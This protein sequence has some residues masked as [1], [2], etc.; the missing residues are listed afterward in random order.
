[1]NPLIQ[2]KIATRIITKRFAAI[3]VLLFCLVAIQARTIIVVTNTN[4]SGFGSLRHA[5]TMAADGDTI[6][7]A[8]TG[9][10]T[11]TSDQ[12]IVNKDVVIEGPGANL[13]RINGNARHRVFFVDTNTPPYPPRPKIVVS[14]SGLTITNGA[15]VDGSGIQ[16]SYADLTVSN[17]T[18]SNNVARE[19]DGGDG[20]G[21]GIYNSGF[22]S[23][24]TKLTVN[25][26]TIIGN[27]ANYGGGIYNRNADSQSG[28]ATLYVDNS[29]ISGNSAYVGGGIQNFAGSR[30]NGNRSATAT[31][32]NST[33]S[34][35]VA[36]SRG[37]GISAEGKGVALF[38]ISRVI[39]NNSTISGNSAR[40]GGAI[41]NF[42][43]A[44]VTIGQT[45]LNTGASGQN[46]YRN[47]N[48]DT[49]TSLGY[50][51][52][53]DD[54]GG[55]LNGPGDQPNTVPLLGPLQHNGGP[56]LTH[57]LLPGSPAIDAGNPSFTPPPHHDQRDC[58]FLRVFGG[59]IDV[60]AFETQPQPQ[61]RPCPR[62]RPRPTPEP[63]RT[64]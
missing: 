42:Y 18:I 60:G 3:A 59:R 50:N 53:N 58:P 28:G 19:G 34:G 15:S 5:L 14:I 17:C 29:T 13:L 41:S 43:G 38:G 35:N 22:V 57:A 32:S 7:F 56:T 9:E 64:P 21:G 39:V 24:E 46:I 63:R 30:R 8:V 55:L 2:H 23:G 4:D 33:I 48:T 1:M 47:R 36:T 31:I 54:G 25:N 20:G 11:L 40:F 37:G 61:S 12:L 52:S 26:C 16:N 6:T 44:S 62:T 27:S 49:I 45:I 51:L 10:I